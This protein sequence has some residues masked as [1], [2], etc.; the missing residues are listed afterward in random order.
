MGIPL[1]FGE[2]LKGWLSRIWRLFLQWVVS[3]LT[4]TP[5]PKKKAKKC[6]WIEKALRKLTSPYF[7]HKHWMNSCSII[8]II[9]PAVYSFIISK[10]SMCSPWN[11]FKWFSS[12]KVTSTIFHLQSNHVENQPKK[13]DPNLWKIIHFEK[14]TRTPQKIDALEVLVLGQR[15][16]ETLEDIQATARRGSRKQPLIDPKQQQKWENMSNKIYA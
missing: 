14:K 4:I 9:N 8:L 13:L 6:V 7:L 1:N 12:T 2:F 3:I 5:A 11:R 15:A 10:P 16:V